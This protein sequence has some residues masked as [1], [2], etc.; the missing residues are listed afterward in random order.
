MAAGG[1]LSPAQP[2]AGTGGPGRRVP[3]GQ[4]HAWKVE[5]LPEPIQHDVTDAFTTVPAAIGAHMKIGVIGS[6]HVGGTLI[7]R[8]RQVGHEVNVANSRGPQTLTRLAEQTGAK[9]STVNDAVREAD[10][11]ILAVP[12]VAVPSLPPEVFRGKVVVDADNYYPERDGDIAELV[13]GARTSSRW[14]AEHLPGSR[15]VKAFN[16][17]HAQDLLE[18]GHPAGATD[19]IA[20]PVAS[21]D[22]EAKRIVMTLVDELGFDPVDAGTLDESWRQQPGTPV[23]GADHDAAGV[24]AG[25]DRAST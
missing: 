11:V 13:D 2:A 4:V 9:A 17:I 5:R 7:R 6:G 3:T 19:R 14:T 16:S 23:H 18:R 12:L 10:L 15:V 25:L 21:D 1:R 8:L 22:E 24:R 20:L